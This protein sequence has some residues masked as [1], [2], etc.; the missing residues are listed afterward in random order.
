MGASVAKAEAKVQQNMLQQAISSCPMVSASNVASG[1]N[2]ISDGCSIKFRQ[3]AKADST[4]VVD[5]AF[6]LSAESIA[7]ASAEAKAAIGVAVGKSA[8]EIEQDLKQSAN[9]VCNSAS[10]SNVLKNS[11]FQCMANGSIDFAQESEVSSKCQIQNAFS[12]AAK[13]KVISDTKAKGFDPTFMMIAIAVI[14][15]IVLILYVKIRSGG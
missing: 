10:A 8:S 5:N 7:N 4:C 15:V 3:S 9:T 13:A 12:Q 1:L 14:A 6:K 11:N 2:F